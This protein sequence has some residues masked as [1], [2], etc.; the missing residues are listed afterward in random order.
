MTREMLPARRAA[1]S[2][3]VNVRGVSYTATLGYYDDG[4]VGEV[5]VDGPKTGTDVETNASDAA[6]IL[7]VALQHGVP[8]AALARSVQRD[9][10]G[11][12]L[13]PVGVLVDLLALREDR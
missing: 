7:S 2:F 13:G 8:P 11:R 3:D 1:T 4:R 6:A 5:F 12:P 9:G 10:D